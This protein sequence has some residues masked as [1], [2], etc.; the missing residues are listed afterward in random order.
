MMREPLQRV[1]ECDRCGKFYARELQFADEG[2]PF[3]DSASHME[4]TARGRPRYRQ[5]DLCGP[6]TGAFQ[7]FLAFVKP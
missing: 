1:Y 4:V 2:H 7:E 3:D 6:C 5:H